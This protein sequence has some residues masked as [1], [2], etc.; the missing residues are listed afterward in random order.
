MYIHTHAA[1]AAQFKTSGTPPALERRVTKQKRNAMPP[2]EANP[3]G[4]PKPF[5][6]AAAAGS[7]EA[8]AEQPA[9]GDDSAAAPQKSKKQMHRKDKVLRAHVFWRCVRC[10]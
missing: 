9:T 2:K 7:A 6:R 1:A 4:N 5:L 10:A 8:K 3:F